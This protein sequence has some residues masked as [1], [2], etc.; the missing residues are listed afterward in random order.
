MLPRRPLAACADSAAS[1][2]LDHSD[3]RRRRAS[4][5]TGDPRAFAPVEREFWKDQKDRHIPRRPKDYGDMDGPL[6]LG[7]AALGVGGPARGTSHSPTGPRAWA[8]ACRQAP[9]CLYCAGRHVEF[10]QPE[11]ARFLLSLHCSCSPRWVAAPA[12]LCSVSSVALCV[13]P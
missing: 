1:L 10:P 5:G 12:I 13:I 2:A 11:G 3:D 7:H 6:R 8:K 4:A 9:L